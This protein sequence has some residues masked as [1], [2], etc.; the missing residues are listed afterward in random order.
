MVGLGILPQVVGGERLLRIV[1]GL[2]AIGDT[3]I[4]VKVYQT[5]R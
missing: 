4:P 2:P 5:F 3:T 1:D